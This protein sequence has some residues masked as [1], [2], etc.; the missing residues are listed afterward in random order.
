MRVWE[1]G[2]E[3]DSQAG[4]RRT[5][6]AEGGGDCAGVGVGVR[7]RC[8]LTADVDG[9]ADRSSGQTDPSSPRSSHLPLLPCSLPS[10]ESPL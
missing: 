9:G 4:T 1:S 3:E 7:S 6:S 5:G 8:F 2:K 10:F